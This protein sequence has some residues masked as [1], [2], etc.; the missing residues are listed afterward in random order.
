MP[1]CL[2]LYYILGTGWS[3]LSFYKRK[4]SIAAE[5][6]SITICLDYSRACLGTCVLSYYSLIINFPRDSM[7]PFRMS[8]YVNTVSDPT[9]L[10]FD[11]TWAPEP[12]PITPPPTNQHNLLLSSLLLGF[13]HSNL[14][15]TLS[16]DEI[17]Y[18][19]QCV[20]PILFSYSCAFWPQVE[21]FYIYCYQIISY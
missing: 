16:G 1:N 7:L 20:F 9:G 13:H 2:M 12:R 15:M 6:L 4:F 8:F 18:K 19:K 21:S 10:T 14:V 11:Q 17:G 5:I 3:Y